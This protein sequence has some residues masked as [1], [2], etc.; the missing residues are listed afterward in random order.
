M[1]H[2]DRPLHEHQL[3][4]AVPI[5]M[6]LTDLNGTC[7]DV[8]PAALNLLGLGCRPAIGENIST[9]LG[10]TIELQV[11]SH[12]QDADNIKVDIL[13]IMPPTA[14]ELTVEC[15]ASMLTL[16]G[17]PAVVYFLRDITD[18][19]GLEEQ[20]REIALKD[21]LTGLPNRYSIEKD[22]DL[23]LGHIARGAPPAVLCFLDLDNFKEV[24]DSRGHAAGDALLRVFSGLVR[25][26]VRA[27]D[28]IGRVG[29]DEFV[30]L[31]NGCPMADAVRYVEELRK[32]LLCLDFNWD[33]RSFNLSLSAGLTLLTAKT[34]SVAGALS[35][36]DMACL[37]AKSAGRGKTRVYS[38]QRRL[39]STNI[40]ADA[41]VL[42]TIKAALASA[43]VP[44]NEQPL[45]PMKAGAESNLVSEIL[46]RIKDT[47]GQLIPPTRLLGV[48]SRYGL[49]SEL[50]RLILRRVLDFLTNLAPSRRC[51][52]FYVNITTSSVLDDAF[53]RWIEDSVP[54]AIAPFVGIEIKESTILLH[55]EATRRLL[56]VARSIGCGVAVDHVSGAIE[57]LSSIISMPATLLKLHPGFSTMTAVGEITYIEADALV[58]IAHQASLQVAM[59]NIETRDALRCA[60]E[61]GADFAQGVAI[62]PALPLIHAP[63]I[64]SS[65]VVQVDEAGHPVRAEAANI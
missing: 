52:C 41:D 1:L 28:A 32:K 45:R 5:A 8:N 35:E 25:D 64:T 40:N 20:L 54:P 3:L 33:G 16:Y 15:S 59:T 39:A 7:I 48:A 37:E 14:Q 23:A 34:R 10:Q 36:A 61:L 56:T 31:L 13:R 12:P 19:L 6:L 50:D 30:V 60:K 58:R 11:N 47:G 49:A 27:T 46:L 22:V 4:A 53:A 55:P 62:S 26:R 44:L 43:A 18:E 65:D 42:D 17:K 24:N 38:G 29:G 9:L 51:R 2:A 63:P 21:P 57:A